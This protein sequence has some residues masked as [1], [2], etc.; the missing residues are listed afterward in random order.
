[1]GKRLRALSPSFEL[2]VFYY[3]PYP[4]NPLADAHRAAGH[5]YPS[6]LAEWAAFDYVGAEPLA[7][8][9]AAAADRGLQVLPAHRLVRPTPLRAPG[10]ALAR[11][12]CRRATRCPSKALVERLRP[13][14]PVS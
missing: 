6:T 2:A 1:M 11:W 3:K 14:V 5:P 7:R 12:R 4:G 9:R 13:P 10:Q 8:R